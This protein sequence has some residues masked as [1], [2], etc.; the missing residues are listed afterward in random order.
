MIFKLRL[1]YIFLFFLTDCSL[2]SQSDEEDIE[3]ILNG[4]PSNNIKVNARN[5]IWNQITDNEEVKFSHAPFHDYTPMDISLQ[6]PIEYFN[7]FLSDDL[8]ILI[9]EQSNLYSMQKDYLKPLNLTVEELEQW[10]G[11]CLQFSIS[12]ITNINLHWK[13]NLSNESVT[14]IM[15]R[16]RWI[17]IKS[18]FHLANNEYIDPTDPIYKVRPLVDNLRVKFNEI[19]M[20]EHLCIDEQIVPFRGKMRMRQY[21]LKKHPNLGYKFI[22]LCDDKGIVYDFIPYTGRIYPVDNPNVPDL[23]SKA[24][25][26]LHLAQCI[27][28]HKNHKLFFNNCFMSLPLVTYLATQGILCCGSIHSKRLPNLAFKS[29]EV[30]SCEGRGSKD[31]WQTEVG[32]IPLVAVK[33]HDTKCVCLLSTFLSDK[34]EGFCTKY[35]KK[36]GAKFKIK[37]P[38]IVSV[39]NNKIKGVDL[40][41]Q[42]IATYRIF[43]RSKKS[44]QHIIFHLLDM[45]IIN[46]WL[47]YRRDAEKLGIPKSK[48]IGLCEFKLNIASSLMKSGKDITRKRGTT[49]SSIDAEFAKKKKTGNATKPIPEKDIRLDKVGHFPASSESRMTCKRPGCSGKIFM[50]C[51]KC[52]VHLCCDKKKNCFYT[53]HNE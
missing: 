21:V 15:S 43:L 32:N 12:K 1:A 27:P 49:S 46:C 50:Y 24:N 44:Y 18:N 48:Q 47:L 3:A 14:S 41:A 8:K 7:E 20:A 31:V 28:T 34:P 9:V 10:I 5:I 11:I 53:F 4:V 51:M 29:D 16:D 42:M 26:V 6:L 35:D 38:N 30:L 52:N 19:P 22:V 37:R 40:H 45:T 13:P 39:Y 25:S 33:W 36:S 17:E 2:P 23:G